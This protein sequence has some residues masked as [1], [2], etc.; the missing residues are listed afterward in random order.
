[1]FSRILTQTFTGVCSEQV[2]RL[3]GESA[4]AVVTGAGAGLPA[5]AGLTYSGE[6]FEDND[7]QEKYGISDM[8]AGGFYP[9]E[10]LEERQCA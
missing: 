6:R 9:F 1:M 8:Y 2:Q 3:K 10:S 5:S 4:D 7:F